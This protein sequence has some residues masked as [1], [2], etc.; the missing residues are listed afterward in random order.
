MA[1]PSLSGKSSAMIFFAAFASFAVKLLW[2]NAD[3]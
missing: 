2:L 3:G 1:A